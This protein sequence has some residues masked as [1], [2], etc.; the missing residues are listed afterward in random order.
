VRPNYTTLSD[1]ARVQAASVVPNSALTTTSSPH[2]LLHNNPGVQLP[3]PTANGTNALPHADASR[4]WLHLLQQQQLSEPTHS[5]NHLSQQSHLANQIL[6]RAQQS[7][8]SGLSTAPRT[9]LELLELLETQHSRTAA[10]IAPRHA[11]CTAVGAAT[12]PIAVDAV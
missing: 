4:L 2:Q 7:S 8:S 12:R 5:L 3:P 10:A 6:H 9:T 1:A 11:G